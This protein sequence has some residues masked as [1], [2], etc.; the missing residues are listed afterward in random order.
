MIL[1]AFILGRKHML[2]VAELINTIGDKAKIIDITPDALIAGFDT[3]LTNTQVYLDRL[4][5][6]IKIAEVFAEDSDKSQLAEHI[7]EFL[8]KTFG[9]SPSKLIYAISLYGFGMKPEE[10]LRNTLND[11]K[12]KLTESG[13]KNRFINKNFT[14]PE[15]AALHGEEIMEKGAEIVAIKGRYK[16]FMG[17]T[18]ALQNIEYYAERDY[19]RPHRDPHLGM[20]PPKLAQIMIN[21]SGSV[22]ILDR[23][24]TD[25][26]LYDPF[27]GLG[28]V[29]G[30]AMLM[31]F[32]VIGSDLEPKVIEK[33]TKNLDWLKNQSTNS[34]TPEQTFRLFC[35][36]ATALSPQDFTEK[37]D[38]VITESYLGPPITKLP[39][40]EEIKK[41]HAHLRETLIRFFG[42]LRQ[43]L[44]QGTPVIICLP[45]Y[46][47]GN[48]HIHLE[49]LTE[50]VQGNGFKFEPLIPNKYAGKFG[51][52]KEDGTSLIYDRP[53]Q[54]VG[55][56]IFKF[57]KTA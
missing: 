33:A 19:K 29:L 6:T 47:Q 28:T 5:G 16:I 37:I 42:C 8:T 13:L 38:L 12:A 3:P 11:V 2:S 40:P 18:A 30:E 24:K 53:D 36:D 31:G 51:L 23:F 41:T 44:A 48:G 17:K 22:S 26:H 50:H 39:S 45:A 55:R 52:K 56:E 34:I 25:Q 14:N 9:G 54:I 21:L 4:G 7:G 57:I 43:I 20:L 27:V 32:S 1:Y 49:G 15:T 46:R 10:I 35:K